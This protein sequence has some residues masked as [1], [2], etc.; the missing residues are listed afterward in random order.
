V[1]KALATLEAKIK[2][3]P[4]LKFNHA[5]FLVEGADE[6]YLRTYVVVLYGNTI[7]ET[8][9]GFVEFKLVKMPF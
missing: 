6:P 4:Q 3:E 2:S 1:P 5:P 8:R 7:P 9:K